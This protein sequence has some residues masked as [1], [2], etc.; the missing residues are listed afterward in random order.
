M[1]GRVRS[2]VP[3]LLKAVD[4]FALTSVS[5]AAS[6]TILE[7]MASSLP[8]VVTAVGG[9]PEMVRDGIEGLLV[10]RGDASATAAALMRLLDDST[11]ACAMGKAGRGCVERRYQLSQTVENY[12]RLYRRLGVRRG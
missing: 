9:N 5:E 12:W 1:F 11:T 8:V 10:P 6:L 3:T 7:A 2:D 4:A